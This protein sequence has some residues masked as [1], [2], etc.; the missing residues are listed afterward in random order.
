[1]ADRIVKVSLTAQVSNYLSGMEKARQATAAAGSEAER[2]ARAVEQQN[3]AMASAGK[4][5]LAVGVV[6]IAATALAVKAAAGW[7]TAWTGVTKTVEGTPEE[8]A[9]VED[10]LRSLAK[11]LP[12]THDDIAAVAE[13]A[14]QLGIQTGAVVAFTK[15]MIDLGETTNMSATEAATQ[16]ARFMN[17]M[18]TAQED[19]D[20]LGS[21]IVELGN[22]FATT[23][24]EIVAMGMRLSG[25][26]RQIGLSE[27]QVLGLATALSSVGIEAEAGGSAISK[28]MI[29][30]ASSV[31]EG[32]DRVEKFAAITGVS[33]KAFTEQWR[34][35][36]GAALAGFV[37][38]LGDA[39]E[40]GGS[41]LTML[42][43]LGITEVRM[44]DA[45]LRASSAS[46][47]FTQAM[48]T[49]SDAFDENNA[50]AAEAA[51]RYDT[52]ESQLR[53]MTNRVNDA[54]I[55]FG[56]VFLPAVSAAAEGIGGFADF[57]GD[58]DPVLQST[59]AAVVLLGGVAAT[60]GG[61][62]LL[63]VPKIAAYQASLQVLSV[64]SI[65]A[66]AASALA[67]QT[68]IVASSAAL[69]RLGAFMLGPWGVALAAAAVATKLLGDALDS[70]GTS[71]DDMQNA[72]STGADGL[73]LLELAGK[74]KEWKYPLVLRND[75]N[76]LSA[77]LHSAGIQARDASQRFN[78]FAKDGAAAFAAFDALRDIGVELGKT[79]Q[80]DL[81]NAQNAFK[82]LAAETDGSA[83]SLKLLLDGMPAYEEEL[84]KQ[85]NT[86]KVNISSTSEAANETALMGLAM[87]RVEDPVL[88]ASDAY[89]AAADSAA[90]LQADLDGLIATINEA[91]GVGQDAVSSNA[92]YQ[93][94]L[95]GIGEEIEA[96]KAAY[97]EANG[98][99][100]DFT[101]SMNEGTVAGSANASMLADVAKDAWDA[102]DAQ[103]QLDLKTM[104]AAEATNKFVGTL[105]VSKQAIIDQ[106]V[107]NGLGADAVQALTDKV[108]AVPDQKMTEF[109][110]ETAA[111]N[112][113]IDAF[114]NRWQGKT[115]TM[116]MFLEST[117]GNRGL[118]ADAARLTAQANAYLSK[119]EGGI[120]PG[121]PS[122]TDNMFIH[123]AS[124]EFVTN[125]KSTADPA[126]R[127]ALE[128]MNNGGKIRGYANGG[129]V[130]PQYVSG[131][132]SGSS[133][134]TSGD[135]FNAS[136][137]LAPVAGRSLSD[138][139][140][141]AARR[142]KIRR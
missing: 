76:D 53:T 41:T 26:G 91:N 106:A 42:E 15:T 35:E 103:Y 17:V 86:L 72:I 136:F 66:V 68:R 47:S 60:T 113:M 43:D 82:A 133:Y 7:E 94:S 3:Q 56:E 114:V 37:K 85:A 4:G 137:Q 140:F 96:Q 14:G 8:L 81:P 127:R 65:P 29:D 132:G 74:G 48:K 78:I 88:S 83:E 139:A 75:I 80:T 93:S 16:L 1:L 142:M 134:S 6:A 71:A 34:S 5:L 54:A 110:I 95:A 13:A 40:Q 141:E 101:A 121:A 99:L 49:G 70:A 97:L 51:K 117:G 116:K 90:G 2:A 67:M 92:A 63:A 25:A 102:A 55:S 122:S 58:M 38:G 104:D 39:E 129:M 138:Q 77:T 105:A 124:G 112:G 115:I 31:N 46:D 19:V 108:F 130:Q 119:A 32:G 30:I 45:L 120:L 111:A 22:N 109:L 131:T 87:G 23:E 12:A 118:A 11:T 52:V 123:A 84:R 69:G 62:F 9:K 50:L 79:A 33:A 61:L 98:T 57:L 59:I 125:A 28:V 64:S 21:A 10:G 100:N 73:R 36:P 107:A 18:G 20:R 128:Y 89:L 126:N 44:R 135:T 24:A 27:G